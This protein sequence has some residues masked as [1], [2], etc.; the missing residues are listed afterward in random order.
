LHDLCAV[1]G[2]AG[3]RVATAVNGEFVA[4]SARAEHRLRDD[5]A[6]EIVAPRQGG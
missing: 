5:D 4:L 1:L 3:A 2:F 6:I